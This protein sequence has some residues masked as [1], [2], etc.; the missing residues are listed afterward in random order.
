MDEVQGRIKIG[1]LTTKGIWFFFLFSFFFFLFPFFLGKKKNNIAYIKV[2]V[3][4]WLNTQHMTESKVRICFWNT[5]MK[6][7]KVSDNQTTKTRPENHW[8]ETIQEC[9]TGNRSKRPELERLNQKTTARKPPEKK[10]FRSSQRDDFLMS[11]N[12]RSETVRGN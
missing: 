9:P 10:T 6:S 5:G 4:Q 8:F 12:S 11:E 1:H 2:L 3:R 7:T